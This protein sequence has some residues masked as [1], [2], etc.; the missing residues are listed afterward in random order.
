VALGREGGSGWGEAMK[1]PLVM[2]WREWIELPELGI[3]RVKAKVDTGARS[4]S[5]HA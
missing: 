4:S 1:S 5:L 2:G 3:R